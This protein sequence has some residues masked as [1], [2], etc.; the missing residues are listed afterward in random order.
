MS[1]GLST[2][3]RK[4]LLKNI[5]GRGVMPAPKM[6]AL[7]RTLPSLSEN[8]SRL[9]HPGSCVSDCCLQN[10]PQSPRF[11]GIL[12]QQGGLLITRSDELAWQTMAPGI[13]DKPL[14]EDAARK[15]NTSLVRM[16]AG[17]HYPSHHHPA[18]EELF[19]LS[20][21]LHL[22]NQ[23]IGPVTTAGLIP[24]RSRGNRH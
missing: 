9:R 3:A 14:F 13:P 8:L 4:S 10:W 12:V 20:G 21:D 16:E 24:A 15:Y 17:A 6:C 22:E 1:W 2:L 11:P 7:L 19:M 18:T 5:Y 23:I